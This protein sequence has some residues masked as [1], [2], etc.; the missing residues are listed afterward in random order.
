VFIIG[1]LFYKS[2]AMFWARF[3]PAHT[4]ALK[5]ADTQ[6]S[7]TNNHTHTYNLSVFIPLNMADGV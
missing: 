5:P 6:V 7:F 2:K 1:V 3:I 4:K